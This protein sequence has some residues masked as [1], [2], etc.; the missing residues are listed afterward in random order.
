MIV[1]NAIPLTLFQDDG[2]Q[3]LNGAFAS[4]IEV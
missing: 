4:S 3:F 2:F 1:C